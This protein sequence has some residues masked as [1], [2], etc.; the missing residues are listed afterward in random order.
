MKSPCVAVDVSKG[1][2]YYQ[3][4]IEIDKPANKATPIQNELEGFKS[5]YE[6]GQTLK[7]TYSDV[8]Y[9]FE[10]TGIYHKALETFL[11][12]HDEKCIILNPLEASKIRKTDLRSTKTDARDC[13][14]IAKAYFMKDFR[15]HDQ[16]DE[17]YEKLHS[18]NGHYTFLI[19]QLREMKVHFRNALDI[20]YPRFDVVYPNPYLDIPM[21]ILKRYAHPYELKNKRFETIVKYIMKD[22][23]HREPK[24]MDEAKKL[25]GYI[26]NVSSGCRSS[27]FEVTILKTMVNKISDQEVEIELCLDEMRELVSEVPLYHQLMSIPGIGDNLAIRL[28]GELGNLDRFERSEQLVAYAGIDPR[29]YQSGQMTGEH[30]HI[31]KKGNKHLR[32]LLFLAMSSNVRIGKTNIILNFYNKKRQQT[33]PLV[34]KAA[35]IACANKLLRIIFGMYKSGKNFH[36]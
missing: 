10:S 16:K 9:V 14:S 33:N 36:K 31:T 29:V 2:S 8:V 11:M 15:L 25:K 22:T 30:L 34:Y 19:Q 5:V 4:F 3:G 27:S 26:D 12:N 17:L 32:T 23:K 13:K 35:L 21:S 18:M 20:V 24:A 28:I 6:L 7:E 1:K